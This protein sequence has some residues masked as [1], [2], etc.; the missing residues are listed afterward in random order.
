MAIKKKCASIKKEKK[1]PSLVS[2]HS[3][4]L[5]ETKFL[6]PLFSELLIPVCYL[7]H[8][9]SVRELSK[10]MK[11]RTHA[12]AKKSHSRTVLPPSLYSQRLPFPCGNH[13]VL[14]LHLLFHC[15]VWDKGMKRA[16]RNLSQLCGQNQC[17][18]ALQSF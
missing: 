17:I 7:R 5:P 2:F 13:T 6:L 9:C 8:I 16:R 1:L 12:S 10:Q 15:H 14:H 4:W 11:L 3:Q 18:R